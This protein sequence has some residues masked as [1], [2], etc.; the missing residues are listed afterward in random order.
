VSAKRRLARKAGAFHPLFYDETSDGPAFV[1]T[2]RAPHGHRAAT[3]RRDRRRIACRAIHW[4]RLVGSI[5]MDEFRQ[6]MD[7]DA[8]VAYVT[9]RC[10]QCCTCASCPAVI[11]ADEEH[12]A[13]PGGLKDLAYDRLMRARDNLVRFVTPR[14]ARPR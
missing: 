14:R 6:P 2:H 11:T 12:Q 5:V 8:R 13:T 10:R 9:A 1:R 3:R 4:K 7:M